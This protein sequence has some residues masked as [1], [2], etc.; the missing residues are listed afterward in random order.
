MSEIAIDCISEN[1]QGKESEQIGFKFD[2]WLNTDPVTNAQ[3]GSEDL[4]KFKF[5]H[6]KPVP[7]SVKDYVANN[8]GIF[9]IVE[10]DTE[11]VFVFELKIND[12]NFELIRNVF[13]TYFIDKAKDAKLTLD[14]SRSQNPGECVKEFKDHFDVPFLLHLLEHSK[15]KLEGQNIVSLLEGLLDYVKTENPSIMVPWLNTLLTLASLRLKGTI[16]SFKKLPVSALKQMD[17][18]QRDNIK[19]LFYLFDN[20][21]NNYIFE[22]GQPG[23]LEISGRILSILNYKLEAVFPNM[24]EFLKHVL[25]I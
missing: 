8:L 12:I 4:L 19:E 13:E 23:R 24:Q 6:S 10:N 14:Y 3:S 16:N 20:P 5:N 17:F 15:L 25:S 2:L 7:E 11:K 1:Y 21:I 9:D 18:D 22:N